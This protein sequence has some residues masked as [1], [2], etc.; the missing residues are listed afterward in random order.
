MFSHWI[1]AR[2]QC[3]QPKTWVLGVTLDNLFARNATKITGT[4]RKWSGDKRRPWFVLR[5][6]SRISPGFHGFLLKFLSID[7][8]L[9]T[10][11]MNFHEQQAITGSH[12]LSGFQSFTDFGICWQSKRLE[13]WAEQAHPYCGSCLGGAGGASTKGSLC[14]RAWLRVMRR[15]KWMFSRHV[16]GW[17][18][19]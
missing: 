6:T 8:Y 7:D 15:Q 14:P 19:C 5:L 17:I 3:L 13:P 1:G 10:N 9:G 18:N 11:F 16:S 12:R 2:L 4:R